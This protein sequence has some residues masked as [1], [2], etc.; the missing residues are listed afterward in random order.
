MYQTQSETLD[1]FVTRCR[2]QALKCDFEATE[3][4]A[5]IIEQIIAS[6]PIEAFQ[7]E[8]LGKDK[9]LTLDQAVEAGR[10]HE[11]ARYSVEK[12]KDMASGMP[13]EIDHIR[14]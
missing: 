9:T 1:E 12:L 10:K 7:N 8:L 13:A 11:A 4:E 6:T 2:T 5:R 3:L 14:Q